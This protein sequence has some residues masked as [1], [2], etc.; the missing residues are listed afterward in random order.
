MICI[1]RY[2]L[3]AAGI[4]LFGVSLC[5][6]DS[7]PSGEA[8]LWE[9]AVACRAESFTMAPGELPY[10]QYQLDSDGSV[11]HR[12]TGRMS[13][14]FSEE[15]KADISILWAKRDGSDFT[16]ERARRLEKQ[17]SRRNEY[18]SLTTPFDPDVQDKLKRGPGEKVISGGIVLWQYEFELPSGERSIAGTARV[19]ED[20]KPYD[21]RYT[22]TPLPWFLDLMEMHLVFDTD[23]EL[24]LFRNID[25]RY[26][27]SF[28]FWLWRGGGHASFDS[29]KKISAPPRLN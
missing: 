12:E 23:A 27:A 4:F 20:G 3:V 26:E 10:E 7:P 5:Y 19:R 18:L 22:L 8:A 16:A 9:A 6:A 13:L 2:R 11:A 24:L 1:F 28:L 15:G 21:F 17:A 29:W 14:D 25:Y